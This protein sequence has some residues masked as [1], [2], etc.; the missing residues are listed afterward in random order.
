MTGRSRLCVAE[1]IA[2]GLPRTRKLLMVLIRMVVLVARLVVSGGRM[3]LL[4]SGFLGCV[5][6]T[7]WVD[8]FS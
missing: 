6:F 3:Y 5:S 1:E 8:G 7:Q 4:C 2:L